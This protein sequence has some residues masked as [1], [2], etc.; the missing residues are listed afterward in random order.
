[1]QKGRKKERRG[2]QRKIGG[3]KERQTA[4]KRNQDNAKTKRYDG[5]LLSEGIF[6]KGKTKK[7]GGMTNRKT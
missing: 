1:M 3:T 6:G 4:R 5:F 7:K 2:K